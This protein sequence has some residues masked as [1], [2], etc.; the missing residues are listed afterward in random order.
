MIEISEILFDEQTINDKVRD[1][2]ARISRDYAGRNLFLI[3]ILKGAFMFTADLMRSIT[4]PVC[5]SF[6]RVSSYGMG[7]ESSHKLSITPELDVDIRGKHVL[8]VDTIVDTGKTL[9][10][11]YGKFTNHNP[12]SLKA[13]VLL[14]KMSRRTAEVSI[15]YRGFEIPNKFVVGYGMDH[16]ERFRNLPY[17]AVAQTSQES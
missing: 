12:A 4:V 3:S 1:L 16:A 6:I 7:T 9:A 15:A 5:V 2:A 8:L 14:D 17:I 11:L 13:V 10:S